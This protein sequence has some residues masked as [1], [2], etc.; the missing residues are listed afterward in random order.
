[1]WY[2]VGR[3]VV[4]EVKLAHLPP[5]AEGKTQVR[6]VFTPDDPGIFRYDQWLGRDGPGGGSFAGTSELVEPCF[7]AH[8]WRERCR[9]KVISLGEALPVVNKNRRVWAYSGCF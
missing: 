6:A 8:D 4:V 5:V 7:I 1:M 3:Q 9:A 2:P